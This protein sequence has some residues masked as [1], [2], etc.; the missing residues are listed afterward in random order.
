MRS[1]AQLEVSLIKQGA[2][3]LARLQCLR[4]VQ[5]RARAIARLIY[6]NLAYLTVF[7]HPCDSCHG[8]LVKLKQKNSSRKNVNRKSKLFFQVI[9]CHQE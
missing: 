9:L 6:R 8:E 2:L 7:T 3:F 5:K 1:A 4:R